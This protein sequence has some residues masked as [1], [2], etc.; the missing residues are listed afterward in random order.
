MSL[1]V[2]LIGVG[3]IGAFHAETL[4]SLPGVGRLTIADADAERAREIALELGVDA[5]STTETLFAAAPDAV[6]VAAPTPAHAPLLRQAAS[7]RVPAFCEKPVALELAALEELAAEVERAGILVQVGFQRR[8][9]AGYRA[10]CD[11]VAAGTLG[12]LLVLRAATHDPA[13]P[14]EAY[15][16]HSGG[17]F[18]DLHIHDFDAIRYVTGDEVVEVYADGAVLETAWFARHGDVDA[19]AA[20][21]S[22]SSGALAVVTGTRHDPLGYDVRLEVFGVA[23]S[24]AVGL[25][26]RSPLRSVEPGSPRARGGYRS[27][28]DRFGAAYRAELAAFVHAVENGLPSPCTLADALAALRIARAADRSRAERRPV[29][30]QGVLGRESEE[31]G[32]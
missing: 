30:V 3:R 16:A 21:L 29:A 17:I 6:V 1:H 25:D 4:R 11:A 12:R 5:A 18:R 20:V 2:G 19:A 24:I 32:N 27:F 7:A 28:V 23:D 9:D 22:L 8:L 31:P 10:A 15:I 26:A 13:P 14:A